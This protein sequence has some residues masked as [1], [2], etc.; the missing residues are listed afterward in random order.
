[1]TPRGWQVLLITAVLAVPVT[2]S[3]IER[4]TAEEGEGR[5]EKEK[6]KSKVGFESE[7]KLKSESAANSYFFLTNDV[8]W[9]EKKEIAPAPR[10]Q[11][12]AAQPKPEPQPAATPKT[13]KHETDPKTAGDRTEDTHL[14]DAGTAQAR[15]T[16]RGK[17]QAATADVPKK[18]KPAKKPA[19]AMP[20]IEQ[21]LA[22]VRRSAQPKLSPEPAASTSSK[23]MSEDLP[24]YSEV[25]GSVDMDALAQD[26]AKLKDAVPAK[27]ARSA[28]EI[29]E[30]GP[31]WWLISA[32][33]TG[34]AIAIYYAIHLTLRKRKQRTIRSQSQIDAETRAFFDKLLSEQRRRAARDPRPEHPRRSDSAAALVPP[35]VSPPPAEFEPEIPAED[36]ADTESNRPVYLLPPELAEGA[37]KEAVKMAAMGESTRGI[38]EKLNLGEGEVR[39]V[40]DI[41]RLTRERMMAA[42]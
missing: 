40:L 14:T 42:G 32:A 23:P 35:P 30:D 37:Y 5:V 31:A 10:P 4:E 36:T 41:A 24:I 12:A 2:S 20:D 28:V 39:L 11:S 22:D 15:P 17:P 21:L 27:P 8:A 16:K 26:L 33:V 7:S 1:M 18:S 19:I 34:I 9:P 38:S 29:P 6:P 13:Q 3:G 25:E